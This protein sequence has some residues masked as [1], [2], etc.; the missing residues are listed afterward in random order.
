MTKRILARWLFPFGAIRLVFFGV[1]RGMRY[2]VGPGIGATFC[3]GG[4]A[5]HHR[6][7]QRVILPG[8]HGGIWE[9]T[10][11][12]ASW[13]WAGWSAPLGQSTHSSQSKNW[14]TSPPDR[15]G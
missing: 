8:M 5:F 13:R 10:R 2:E 12:R 14:P 9:R 7:Y 6:F 15:S 11:G 4:E 1:C 3:L